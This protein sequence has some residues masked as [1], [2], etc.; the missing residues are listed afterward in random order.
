MWTE[1]ILN[2]K[3]ISSLFKGQEPSLK[4]IKAYEISVIFGGTLQVKIHFDLKEFLAEAP[5]KWV[6]SKYDTVGMSLGLIDADIKHFSVCGGEMIGDLSI[7]FLDSVFLIEFR[8]DKVGLIFSATAK[9]INVDKVEG[10]K[11][12]PMH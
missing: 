2:P 8:T 4:Q 11:S 12:N 1:H 9:W 7:D 3:L 10:Y 6:Q 5:M